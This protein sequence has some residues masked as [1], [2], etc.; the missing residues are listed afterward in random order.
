MFSISFARI[1][2]FVSYTCL[3]ILIFVALCN[4][5]PSFMLKIILAARAIPRLPSLLVHP[6]N[7]WR[8]CLNTDSKY[9]FR[10]KRKKII[11]IHRGDQLK[12]HYQQQRNCLV[13]GYKIEVKTVA[14]EF[15]GKCDSREL[16]VRDLNTSRIDT[17]KTCN[18]V[19]VESED[20]Y[21]NLSYVGVSC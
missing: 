21:Y 6:P 3:F 7:A 9:I 15:L 11:T 20:V 14:V 16:L 13:E 2:L 4:F 18:L 5:F 17:L 8:V 19:G 10:E 12:F 1:G